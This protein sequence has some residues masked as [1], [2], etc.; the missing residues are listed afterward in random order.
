[1]INDFFNSILGERVSTAVAVGAVATPLWLQSLEGV[2]Y[3]AGLI[4]PIM[5]VTWL[6]VQ[7]YSH[8]RKK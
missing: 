8:I 6:G 4:L 2:S 7:M 1:M 5:G 3:F